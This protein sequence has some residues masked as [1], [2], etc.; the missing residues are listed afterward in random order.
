[1][2][3]RNWDPQHLLHLASALMLGGV[4][5]LLLGVSGAYLFDQWLR[6]RWWSPATR[7]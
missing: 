4:L 1:M 7:W 5:L 2:F 6:C 3:Q